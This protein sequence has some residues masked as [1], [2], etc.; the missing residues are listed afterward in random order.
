MI[1]SIVNSIEVMALIETL[2]FLTGIGGLGFGLYQYLRARQSK[3]RSRELNDLSDKLNDLRRSLEAV[4]EV[5]ESPHSKVDLS[6]QLDSCAKDILAFHHETGKNAVVKSK[7]WGGEESITNAEQILDMYKNSDDYQR[8]GL[9]L[10]SGHTGY[11][12]HSDLNLIYGISK[13]SY[14]VNNI[15]KILDEVQKDH[16]GTI[17]EFSPGLYS[18]IEDGIDK[19]VQSLYTR[20][21]EGPHEIE[22]D[23]SD[24]NNIKEMGE[25]LYVYFWHYPNIQNDIDDLSDIGEKVE[26]TRTTI[27]QASYS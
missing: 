13:H 14:Y 9:V 24:F 20:M 7:R 25:F 12:S 26:D 19:F 10:E 6:K 16:K 21:V 11:E 5:F 18:E 27:L 2:G 1:P 15:Y 3:R 17:E 23:P 22:V 4:N 8:Y